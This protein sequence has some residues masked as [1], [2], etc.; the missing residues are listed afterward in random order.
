[1]S[2][3]TGTSKQS[4]QPCKKD[5]VV[6]ST[7]CHI[8]GG[9]TPKG[10]DSPNLKHGRYSAYLKQ[11]MQD[12]LATVRDENPL[13]LLPELDAQRMLFAEYLSRFQHGSPTAFDIQSMQGW[14]NDIGRQVERIVK[15]K[16]ETAL[17]NAEV[18]FLAMRV[19]ELIG[20]YVDP[21]KQR[22]FVEEFTASIPARLPENVG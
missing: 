13:D 6:G 18:Q 2:K 17:T 9:A 19:M 11:S 14:L 3:C 16:N 12:K 7:K 20:K 22:A 1:M 8:H 5:A 21:D 10:A 4:G 15:M